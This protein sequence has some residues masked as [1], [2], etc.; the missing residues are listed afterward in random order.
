MDTE[1]NNHQVALHSNFWLLNAWWW[2]VIAQLVKASYAAL[3]YCAI[4]ILHLKP[5]AFCIYEFRH[6]EFV[7]TNLRWTYEVRNS[8]IRI[9]KFVYPAQIRIY[10]FL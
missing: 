10:E 9:S 5:F 2:V 4:I 8:N 6:H 3:I 7:Y 1:R